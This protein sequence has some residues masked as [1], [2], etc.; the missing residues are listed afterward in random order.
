MCPDLWEVRQQ[1]PSAARLHEHY[2]SKY[3]SADFRDVERIRRIKHHRDRFEMAVYLA[4]LFGA[5]RCLEVGAGT[6][7]T[8]LTLLDSYRELVGTEL[9]AIRARELRKLFTNHSQ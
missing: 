8:M 1:L 7:A 9:S 6:G 2:D 5:D 3:A 4:T